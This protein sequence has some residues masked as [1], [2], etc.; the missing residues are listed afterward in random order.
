KYAFNK[1]INRRVFGVLS[2]FY[3]ATTDPDVLQKMFTA[4]TSQETWTHLSTLSAEKAFELNG[5]ADR[6]INSDAG[7]ALA[8]RI[9]HCTADLI[10]NGSHSLLQEFRNATEDKLRTFFMS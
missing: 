3:G 7:A 6:I 10:A 1:P 2:W 8:Q 9:P 4:T 5:T